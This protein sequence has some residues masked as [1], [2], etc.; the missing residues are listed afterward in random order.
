MKAVDSNVND[1][2]KEF[3]TRA[4]KGLAKYGVTT[5]RDDLSMDQWIQH[6]KEELMDA[7]VYI[8]KLQKERAKHE[9]DE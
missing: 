7:V 1:V 2:C 6:L 9:R 5:E 8:Q 4:E 3:V